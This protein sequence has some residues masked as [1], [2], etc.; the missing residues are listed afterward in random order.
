MRKA[1]NQ[2][3]AIEAF[4]GISREYPDSKVAERGWFEAGVCYE[5]LKELDQAAATFEQLTEKFPKGAQREAAF[6]RAAENY[7][8]NNNFERAAQIY[9]T[10]ANQIPKPEF[11]I[12]SL[13][14]ASEAYQKLNQYDMAGKMFELIYE[15][16]AND[17]KTPQALYNAGLI[18]EKGKHYNNAIGVY[19]ALAQRYP[20]SEFAGEAFFSIGLCWEKL[21]E[22]GK[23]ANSFSDYASKYTNDRFKQVQALVK[24][25][26]AYFNMQNFKD[27]EANYNQAVRVYEQHSKTSDIDAANIAEAYYRLG[28][29]RYKKFEDIKLDANNEK[30]MGNLVRDKT[31][32][33]E[34]PAKY[35]AK[36][37]E[38]GVEEWTM[39]ATYMIGRGFYDMAEAVANQKLFGNETERM[40]GKIKVLSSLEKYYERAMQ[41]FGQNIEW[42]KG[43]NLSGEYI[44]MSMQA[45]IEMAFKKG[46]ILEEVGLLFKNSP[47]PKGLSA[48]EV[49][50][51]TMELEERYLKA[52]DAAMPKYEEALAIAKEIGIG[53]SEWVDRTRDRLREI[54]P[55]SDAINL[56]WAQWK[57]S[58]RAKQFD[59]DGNEII[60]R[61]KDP[62]YDRSIRRI[63]SILTM[64]IPVAE[65]IKQLNRMQMEA[66]RA[67]VLE[68]ERINELKAKSGS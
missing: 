16:Y 1:G 33:L 49:E 60:P 7:K 14:S 44:E 22:Y 24:A 28:D 46:H 40:A 2:A 32:A 42:A 20:N 12:P 45:M 37:I 63:Q 67:I 52:L 34:E 36:A 9:L 54:N 43:Q 17:P 19:E 31:K 5:E 64:N 39:R 13:S 25:G 38:I 47:V 27:S 11:A 4:K 61:G 68:Q 3:A 65:K 18:F 55:E 29:I 41:Y 58:E 59:E 35:F 62:E 26:N 30:S 53:P 15:R 10:A 6:I 50:F 66:E 8:K 57:P 48:E 21:E 23:M 51:Y 56:Q